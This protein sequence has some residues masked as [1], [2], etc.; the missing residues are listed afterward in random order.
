MK[1]TRKIGYTT[2]RDTT[3]ILSGNL[4]GGSHEPVCTTTDRAAVT[5]EFSAIPVHDSANSSSLRPG[6]QP[7]CGQLV[8]RSKK[9]H[10]EERYA[11]LYRVD[12]ALPVREMTPAKWIAHDRAM[13]A[14]QTCPRCGVRFEACLPLKSLGSCWACSD[15]AAEFAAAA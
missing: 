9:S 12:L 1:I 5:C 4:A 11:W 10:G 2:R 13:A 3:S 14:R 15:E 6:G 8:W 7:V